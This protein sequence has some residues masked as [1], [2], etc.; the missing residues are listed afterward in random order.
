MVRAVCDRAV[1]LEHGRLR[2][3]A[4]AKAA[5]SAYQAGIRLGNPAGS[6]GSG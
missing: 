1:W 3:L 2:L 5:V 6:M 4:D